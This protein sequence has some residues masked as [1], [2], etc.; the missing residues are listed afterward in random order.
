MS[1]GVGIGVGIKSSNY[2]TCTLDPYTMCNF[3][4]LVLFLSSVSLV[5]E[6]VLLLVHTLLV[7][8]STLCPSSKFR[9]QGWHGWEWLLPFL[10]S[11]AVCRQRCAAL[12]S[13]TPGPAATFFLPPNFTRRVFC[14]FRLAEGTPSNCKIPQTVMEQRK[15]LICSTWDEHTSA[16]PSPQSHN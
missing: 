7:S 2:Q 3:P 4:K 10:F 12:R 5:G 11:L 1:L 9:F 16:T 15:R 14:S 6:G 13:K 8:L